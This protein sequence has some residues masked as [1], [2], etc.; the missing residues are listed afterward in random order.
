MH[1][2]PILSEFDNIKRAV[3]GL[4]E[5]YTIADDRKNYT[6]AMCLFQQ[7]LQETSTKLESIYF[8]H[9]L[10]PQINIM[11]TRV[12]N[13]TVD[14]ASVLVIM[15]ITRLHPGAAFADLPDL[16]RL[17]QGTLV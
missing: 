2:H 10:F 15:Y 7:T 3:V 8:D 12:R 13:K 9:V 1:S 17:E 11:H 16:P 5:K 4:L 14:M 6:R